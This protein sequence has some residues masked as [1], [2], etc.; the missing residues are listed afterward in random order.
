[1]RMLTVI[2]VL[3][4]LVPLAFSLVGILNPDAIF[5]AGMVVTDAATTFAL[6]AAARSTVLA[7]FVIF[8]ALNNDASALRLLGLLAGSVQFLDAG[9]GIYQN[10]IG[11]TM[12]PV[13]LAAL[14]A[15]ALRRS[16]RDR[17]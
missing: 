3:N 8:V 2:T 16:A 5:H 4:V 10:D 14:Q 15:W 7:C 1:M 17:A 9:V 12:G 6:Y 13:A 11:K